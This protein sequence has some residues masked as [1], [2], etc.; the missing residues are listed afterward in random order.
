MNFLLT[1]CTAMYF[2]FLFLLR[3]IKKQYFSSGI[4]EIPFYCYA[5]RRRRRDAARGEESNLCADRGEEH[6]NEWTLRE[7]SSYFNS[8]RSKPV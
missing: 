7:T 8:D 6:N 5:L 4:T 2:S 1:I 3:N